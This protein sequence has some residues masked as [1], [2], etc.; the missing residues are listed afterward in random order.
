M[1]SVEQVVERS[2][3]PPHEDN[4][5]RIEG[6]KDAAEAP[7]RHPLD[8]TSFE[9]RDLVL[10]AR[11]LAGE[12]LLAHVKALSEHARNAASS[13]VV[14]QQSLVGG[15]STRPYRPAEASN[16]APA[17]RWAIPRSTRWA[18]PHDGSPAV[19]S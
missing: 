1:T 10:A 7:E 2:S 8:P 15:R 9:E 17:L 18:A 19:R 16:V 14:H 12:V 3:A 4:N 11:G 5:L 6:T 13:Q